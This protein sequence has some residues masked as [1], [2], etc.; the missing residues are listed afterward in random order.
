M[1]DLCRIPKHLGRLIQSKDFLQKKTQKVIM[2]V[3]SKK[4]NQQA[5]TY[6]VTDLFWK[7][8][9]VLAI[10]FSENSKSSN[11]CGNEKHKV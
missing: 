7:H 4:E 11:T 1:D 9:I 5:K 2:A 10:M 6:D 8:K 3:L